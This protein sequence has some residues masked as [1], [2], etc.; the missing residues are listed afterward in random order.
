MHKKLRL[1]IRTTTLFSVL[2]NAA[3]AMDSSSQSTFPSS[4]NSNPSSSTTISMTDVLPLETV[5][6]FS[7]NET[8]ANVFIADES[9]LIPFGSILP[10]GTN[11]LYPVDLEEIFVSG[12]GNACLFN[13]LRTYL[14]GLVFAANSLDNRRHYASKIQ[15]ALSGPHAAVLQNLLWR[16]FLNHLPSLDEGTLAQFVATFERTS[17]EELLG[18]LSR[19]KDQN[20]RA[21]IIQRIQEAFSQLHPTT[22]TSFFES[23]VDFIGRRETAESAVMIEI[24]ATALNLT[25]IVHSQTG[26]QQFGN[27]PTSIQLHHTSY[28]NS[29]SEANHYNLLVN[30]D[31]LEILG[32]AAPATSTNEATQTTQ[33]Q[34]AEIRAKLEELVRTAPGNADPNNPWQ[35]LRETSGLSITEEDF[36]EFIN[37]LYLNPS[38]FNT[39]KTYA[40]YLDT[41]HLNLNTMVEALNFY[42][43]KLF[44]FFHEKENSKALRQLIYKELARLGITVPQN[45][46][47]L[48]QTYLRSTQTP[49]LQGLLD[50]IRSQSQQGTAQTAFIDPYAQDTATLA[51]EAR[52]AL[53]SFTPSRVVAAG[54][55]ASG[56]SSSSGSKT[57]P[58]GASKPKGVASPKKPADNSEQKPLD[59]KSRQQLNK[60]R[61]NRAKTSPAEPQGTP[62]SLWTKM[63]TATWGLAVAAVAGGLAWFLKDNK[64]TPQY[65]KQKEKTTEFS[66]E[67]LQKLEN[68]LEEL[69]RLYGTPEETK[70]RN[71]KEKTK[72]RSR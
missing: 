34:L 46:K 26:L 28:D 33:Q 16:D 32:Q 4:P 24:L 58:L 1:F 5:T 23:Y 29:S 7:F 56:S 70:K 17:L 55:T 2:H 65:A 9:V 42:H 10:P 72:K 3:I 21:P 62:V 49:T 53:T 60:E 30:P 64:T 51:Q 12:E 39:L 13:A 47:E 69:F 8:G 45:L 50:F 15:E 31:T 35:T 22:P 71:Q 59:P 18:A 36:N 68:Q 20:N 48:F 41:A 14:D 44:Q 61:E 40:L 38:D 66:T 63:K 11:S 25:I 67:E 19:E 57:P 43:K 54:V 37:Q 6:P 27:G 52:Q